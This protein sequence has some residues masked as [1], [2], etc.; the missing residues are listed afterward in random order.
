M[1]AQK[2]KAIFRKYKLQMRVLSVVALILYLV[3]FYFNTSSVTIIAVSLVFIILIRYL[4]LFLYNKHINSILT[5]DMDPVLFRAVIAEG[6]LIS[7]HG[8]ERLSAAYYNQDY[9]T[10][11]DICTL[12][13]KEQKNEK[14]RMYYL[15]FLA[16]T[17]FELGDSVKLRAVCDQAEERILSGKNPDQLRRKHPVFQFY[18]LYLSGDYASCRALYESV[19]QD[20][21]LQSPWQQVHARFAYAIA[22]YCCGDLEAAK[23]SFSYVTE[24]APK[25]HLAALSQNYLDAM[26]AGTEYAPEYREL[27]PTENF[28]M[29]LYEEKKK[30]LHKFLVV[31]VC[32]VV[33]VVGLVFHFSPANEEGIYAQLSEAVASEFD[34]FE[35]V[36]AF[37]I[38]YGNEITGYICLIDT[39]EDGLVFGGLY[40]ADREEGYVFAAKMRG[41]QVG[42]EYTA[43]FG[44]EY[45][46]PSYHYVCFGLFESEAE[47]PADVAYRTVEIEVDGKDYIFGMTEFQNW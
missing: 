2:A 42:D 23:E 41:I 46:F 10:V 17:Y 25:L 32:L 22:C 13:L 19:L 40:P 4:R 15:T 43:A 14:Y 33:V 7:Q 38:T 12:K 1:E 20:K 28:S 8:A 34:D 11:I 35:I 26:E 44:G 31:Y 24:T 21:R 18:S 5:K 47:V 3:Y 30:K 6:D 27:L 9:Q 37:N 36:K 16:R 39:A 45:G 29:S